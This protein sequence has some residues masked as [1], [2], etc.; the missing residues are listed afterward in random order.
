MINIML[1]KPF[2]FI[3]LALTAMSLSCG[4]GDTATGKEKPQ[5]EEEPVKT[6][7]SKRPHVM[8]GGKVEIPLDAPVDPPAKEP[9]P[10]KPASETT[11]ALLLKKVAA[12]T[13]LDPETLSSALSVGKGAFDVASKV[14][15]KEKA[16]QAGLTAAKALLPSGADES[17]LMNFIKEVL[18]GKVEKAESDLKAAT[19]KADKAREKLAEAEENLLLKQGTKEQSKAEAAVKRATSAKILAETAEDA[20]QKRLEKIQIGE[21]EELETEEE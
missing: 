16:L 5:A 19:L 4:G 12:K 9:K 20:A 7:A 10:K 17:V 14:L 1:S 11:E 15:G 8:R 6:T 3:L 2:K 13:G 18:G 21:L